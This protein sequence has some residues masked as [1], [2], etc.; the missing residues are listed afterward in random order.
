[1]SRTRSFVLTL[2]T[3]AFLNPG[4]APAIII[5][6]TYGVNSTAD[7]ADANPGDF[8]CETVANNGVCTLRAA[9]MEANTHAFAT[10][11][12][13]AGIYLL[14][15]PSQGPD[16]AA[17][18]DLDI[19]SDVTIKGAGLASTIIDADV[20]NDRVFFVA[21]DHSLV[22]SGVML[23]YGRADAGGAI[24][25]FGSL[26][27]TDC[28]ITNCVAQFGGAVVAEGPSSTFL[29][30]RIHHCQSDNNGGAL[31][32]YGSG[33]A[34]VTDCTIE[35]N[36]VVGMGSGG[37]IYVDGTQLK[38]S[39]STI[40]SNYA[41]L[42]GG[43]RALGP[44]GQLA[45]VN[46]TVSD[47]NAHWDGGGIHSG[48]PTGLYSATVVFNVADFDHNGNQQ[49]GGGEGGGIF[50][51]SGDQAITLR[52][53]ILANNQGTFPSIDGYQNQSRD[54]YGL[55]TSNG[56]S[57]VGTTTNCTLAGS[58]SVGDPLLGPLQNNGGRTATRALLL[59]SPGIDSGNPSGCDDD[60]GA[61]LTA[62]QRG[63]HRALGGRC[64]IGAY[65]S[66]SPKGDVNGDGVVDVADVF[67]LIN[68]LFAAGP[69]PPGIANVDGNSTI[70]VAD[71]FYLINFLFAG[72]PV[73]A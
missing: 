57:L 55:V 43:I 50:N 64:D 3:L 28:E 21:Q 22:L 2:F 30:C 53:T 14:A 49:L 37:G 36:N 29:R 35:I 52:D 67:F 69:F 17:T 54:C 26:D 70:T 33:T 19:S 1:M 62:D 6:P 68:Y 63:V 10:I 5:I 38:L 58:Y 60:V 32:F 73:P 27:V 66:G 42:G 72:G 46:T 8:K 25:A 47:N 23:R 13:P 40:R 45:I 11:K 12:L 51:E 24:R 31:Y 48:V 9:V 59:G 34:E 41:L 20:M 16:D 44:F 71:V 61:T 65:E 39:G 7:I 18:G 56:Y 15:I 4:D